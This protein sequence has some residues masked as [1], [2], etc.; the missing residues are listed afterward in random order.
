MLVMLKLKEGDKSP[1]RN[2]HR[3][4]AREEKDTVE[5]VPRALQCL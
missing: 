1:S 4:N 5:H 3:N 2:V